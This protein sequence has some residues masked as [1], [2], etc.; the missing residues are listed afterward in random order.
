MDSAGQSLRPSPSRMTHPRT[1][2]AT[3]ALA[4]L[5]A[6]CGRPAPT[7]MTTSSHDPPPATKPLQPSPPPRPS[8]PEL[9]LADVAA[10]PLP[11]MIAPTAVAFTPDDGA[12]SY[13][14]SPDRSLVRQLYRFDLAHQTGDAAGETLLVTPPGGGITE[15]NL[16]LEEKLQRER[17]RVREL[18][19]HQLRVV[20]D[21]RPPA[22]PADRRDLR[23]SRASSPRSPA[24]SPPTASPRS[25]PSSAATAAR[26]P[27]SRTPSSTSSTPTAAQPSQRTKGARGTGKTHGLAEYIAQEE[28]HRNHG[29]WWSRDGAHLAFTE[30]DETHIPIYRIVHQGKDAR[31]RRPPRRTTPTRSPGPPTPRS[32]SAS[33]RLTG[34]DRVTW[35]DL[36]DDPEQY[37][38][39]VQWLPD[40]TLTAQV[41]TAPRQ[42][43][44]LLRSTR[45]PARAPP[46][47]GVQRRVDQPP[48]HARPIAEG[49]FAGHFVWA[50]ERSGFRHLYLYEDDGTLVRALTDGRV[51]GRRD[52]RHRR[53]ARPRLLHRQP[54]AP[55]RDP[56]PLR[57]PARRRRG[58]RA[59]P[60]SPAPTAS[61]STTPSAASSTP[62]A[63][64]P[65]R[66]SRPCAR[67][68]T[69]R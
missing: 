29:F 8:Q 55:H 35:M 17:Q 53:G 42:R 18:G 52:R 61:S 13:L 32:A 25:R 12:L 40:G 30:V 3:L 5:L 6:A 26:S 50:S 33:S 62:S 60:P 47:S 24:W 38:A 31:R 37:L 63:T 11:G 68:T 21:R 10:Y 23:A 44:T 49:P 15:D 20:E 64:S 65:R 2:R 43:L 39:R 1:A 66:R 36:G 48:R 58:P 28:M 67:S 9:A 51:A 14:R 46:C 41:E 19:D 34:S 4:G 56:A 22:G 69:A 7:P 57:R 59:S 16:S 54:R 45:R 27:T